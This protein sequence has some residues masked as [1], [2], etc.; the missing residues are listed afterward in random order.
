MNVRQSLHILGRSALV[1]TGVAALFLS[2]PL[3]GRVG[4]SHARRLKLRAT[5][6]QA[7]PAGGWQKSLQRDFA[8]VARN[9]SCWA[10]SPYG[11]PAS[12]QLTAT[13]PTQHVGEAIALR[14][15]VLDGDGV[16]VGPGVPVTFTTTLGVVQPSVAATDAEGVATAVITSTQSGLAV[17]T[18]VAGPAQSSVAVT[19][20]PGPL[21]TIHLEADPPAIPVDGATSQILAT[22]TDRFGNLVTDDVTVTFAT[23]L[24]SIAPTT[25]TAV[26]GQA[27]AVLTSGAL[28]GTAEV[29]ATAASRIGT[30]TVQIQPADLVITCSADPSGDIL[31]GTTVTYTI[32]Y[33]NQGAAVARNVY[34]TDTLP[35]G[36]I[37]PEVL[38]WSGATITRTQ[39]TT[40]TWQVADLSPGEGGTIVLRGHFDRNRKWPS[41][42]FVTNQVLIRSRTAD[43]N[44][45]D[46]QAAAGNL[47]VTADLYVQKSSSIFNDFAPGRR[48]R[49]EIAFGNY[50]RVPAENVYIT[51]TLPAYTRLWDDTS[52]QAGLIR[53]SAPDDPV[54]VWQST[55][56][57]TSANAGQFVVWLDIDPEAPGGAMLD[58]TVEIGTTTPESD[59]SNNRMSV[60][61][62]LAGVNLVVTL[63][64]PETVRPGQPITYTLRY[65]NTGHDPAPATVLTHTLPAGVRFQSATRPPNAVGDGDA[66]WQL[67]ELLAGQSGLIGVY[68]TVAETVR[69]GQP[70]TSVL[71]IASAAVESYAAD[72]EA[73]WSTQVVPDAPFTLTVASLYN[74]VPVGGTSVPIQ[75]WVT[76][77]FG[78]PIDGLT[79]T[80]ST[81][82]GVITP[83]TGTTANGGLLAHLISPTRV[84]RAIVTARTGDLEDSTVVEFRPGP[85]A[86][87]FLEAVPREIPADGRSK[88]TL[89][90][91]VLDAY[92]NPVADNTPV[93]FTTT[94]GRLYNGSSR[95]IV[96][97]FDGIAATTLQAG[98][99]PGT[100]LV[101]AEVEGLFE[102][103]EVV[104]R[105]VSTWWVYL[106]LVARGTAPEH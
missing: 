20:L 52:A 73:Q 90:A 29:T 95:H 66:V 21:E 9:F 30:T 55:V 32:E 100:A 45:A 97:T 28:H 49:Y 48:I 101:Q 3:V 64:G 75:V 71:S 63:R 2:F 83:T 65:T 72:N 62:I 12:I 91:T 102:T 81:T 99:T 78:N 31:P 46:N 93:V 17:V 68:G 103:V 50:Q 18:A 61:A 98:R 56:P 79:V 92:G 5:S 40:F 86:Q 89:Y 22:L 87:L 80:L 41:S 82:A 59:D 6:Y 10:A 74:S 106:P 96:G 14:A 35:V 67:G 16:P 54:Q 105:E 1:I 25:Q 94:L 33:R 58:N 8:G 23:S 13:P 69:A 34:I 77:R 42:Q 88:A 11:E 60:T 36:F 47:I 104:L 76:D 44:W 27:A 85:P 84:G 19:F 43:G 70:I 4:S 51:D 7:A 24:G 15:Q 57:V 37:E 53:L 39:G 38:S 26:A